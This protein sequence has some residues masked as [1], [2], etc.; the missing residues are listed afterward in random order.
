MNRRTKAGVVA[1][2]KLQ[3]APLLIL[4]VIVDHCHND[5]PFVLTALATT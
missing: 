2:G 4:P 5:I 1:T 3:A